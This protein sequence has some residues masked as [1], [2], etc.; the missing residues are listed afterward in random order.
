MTDSIPDFDQL[1]LGAVKDRVRSLT[2]PA[3]RELIE[4]EE[5]HGN[6]LPVLEILR[7]RLEQLDAGAQ[8]TGGDPTR[9]PGAA[10]HAHGSPV[11][12]A[13]A[14]ES[15]TPLRHGMAEQTPQ[16]GRQ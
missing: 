10:K 16:R 6:R 14:A 15:T 2:A 13:T 1:P 12:E 11:Q 9:A 7:S 4:H 5:R 8:P 3:L